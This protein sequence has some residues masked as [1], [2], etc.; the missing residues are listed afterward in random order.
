LI[1][2]VALSALLAGCASGTA[3]PPHQTTHPSP[4]EPSTPV[5]PQRPDSQPAAVRPPQVVITAETENRLAL[6]DLGRGKSATIVR[7]VALPDDPEFVAAGGGRVVVTSPGAG[8]VTILDRRSHRRLKVLR[9]FG[10]PHIAEISADG[11]YAYVTDDARGQLDVIDLRLARVVARTDVGAEAH[12]MAMRPDGRRVWVAL[13]ESAR[14]IVIVDTSDPANPRVVGHFD[15]GFAVHDL[16]FAPDGRRV[17]ITAAS[18]DQVSVLDARTRSVVFTVP[19]G[20]PPQHVAFDAHRAYIASGYGSQLEAVDVA[21]GRVIKVV[22][23]PYGSFNLDARNAFVTT[24]SLSRGVL[25]VYDR[26]L[27][28]QRTLRIAPAAR[29][30]AVLPPAG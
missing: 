11:R 28:L 29:D 13:G 17:W 25:A 18:E 7:R 22:G 14:T 26:R 2:A 20:A 30:V 8:A 1:L 4:V 3:G 9:G 27:R 19:G 15:P 6:V 16:R 21:S 24:S 12:H 10:S 23:A 5:G